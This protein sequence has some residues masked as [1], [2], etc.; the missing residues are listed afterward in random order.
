VIAKRALEVALESIAV[1]G[2]LELH[3]VPLSGCSA[4][5][6][7]SPNDQTILSRVRPPSTL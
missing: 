3:Q 1:P 4:F 5:G 6:A 7:A 2:S